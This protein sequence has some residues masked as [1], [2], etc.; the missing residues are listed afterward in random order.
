LIPRA[1]MHVSFSRIDCCKGCL[2]GR[3]PCTGSTLNSPPIRLFRLA[4]S[5]S[6]RRRCVP[7]GERSQ[8]RGC[9]RDSAREGVFD[10]QA[11]DESL[12]RM[13]P[14]RLTATLRLAKT[15]S[16][17]MRGDRLLM[18]SVQCGEL[19]LLSNIPSID[20]LPTYRHQFSAM[21]LRIYFPS[22]PVLLRRRVG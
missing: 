18:Y 5:A 19:K 4:S 1:W 7:P 9:D 14:N 21:T 13:R 20:G 6:L 17:E 10:C 22:V 12:P 16:P 8:I 11:N 3:V 2:A 15:R